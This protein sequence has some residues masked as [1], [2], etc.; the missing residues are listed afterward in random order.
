MNDPI[1]IEWYL[2]VLAESVYKSL[3]SIGSFTK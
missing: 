3:L 1:K 2:M